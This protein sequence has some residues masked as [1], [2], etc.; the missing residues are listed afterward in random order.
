MEFETTNLDQLEMDFLIPEIILEIVDYLGEAKD[1]VSF[2]STSKLIFK[3][4]KENH[5]WKSCSDFEPMPPSNKKRFVRFLNYMF[6][7]AL[8]NEWNFLPHHLLL[9]EKNIE[10]YKLLHSFGFKIFNINYLLEMTKSKNSKEL[11]DIFIKMKYP[12]DDLL[13]VSKEESFQKYLAERN[14]FTLAH[15]LVWTGN[16]DL[17]QHLSQK[18]V[19]D[20]RRDRLS[21]F[22]HSYTFLEGNEKMIE[23]IED[24][25]QQEHFQG[26]Y[27]YYNA[28][29]RN[30]KLKELKSF[31]KLIGE[32]EMNVPNDYKPIPEKEEPKEILERTPLKR[33][34]FYVDYNTQE[35]SDSDEDEEGIDLDFIFN[36]S[37]EEIKSEIEN[38]EKEYH[39]PDEKNEFKRVNH[40]VKSIE[41]KPYEKMTQNKNKKRKMEGFP[42]KKRK[43]LVLEKGDF[44]EIVNEVIKSW[45]R[46]IT[47]LAK[48]LLQEYVERILIKYLQFNDTMTHEFYNPYHQLPN[49]FLLNYFSNYNQEK[50]LEEITD[51]EYEKESSEES[52]E[53]EDFCESSFHYGNWEVNEKLKDENQNRGEETSKD[54]KEA[55]IKNYNNYGM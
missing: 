43:E 53:E 44:Q 5:F 25:I 11:F 20:Y 49:I 54:M 47:F 22:P 21:L 46:D 28:A 31:Q 29:K 16:V 35:I 18:K 42:V 23:Y 32:A 39:I 24:E 40:Y 33:E 10:H 4:S 6:Y 38:F 27:L 7:Y 14:T 51:S 9:L 17:Y 37:I 41:R 8:N 50:E 1:K 36:K 12:F 34:H 15:Y 13:F 45:D 48:F 26:L 55:I 3:V 19:L 30:P 2:L 52:E